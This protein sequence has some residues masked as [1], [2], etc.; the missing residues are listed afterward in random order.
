MSDIF[1][2][3]VSVS[4]KNKPTWNTGKTGEYKWMTDGYN[5]YQ[6][7]QEYWGE[8]IDIGFKFGRTLTNFTPW[9]KNNYI[10]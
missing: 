2:S 4:K 1:C 9:N 3:K 7:K 5:N 8:F 6:L 10:I